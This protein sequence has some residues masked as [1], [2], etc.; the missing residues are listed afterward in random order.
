MPKVINSIFAWFEGLIDPFKDLPVDKPPKELLA[1]YWHYIRQVWLFFVALLSIG[2]V[3]ALIEVSLFA[4]LGEIVDLV[5]EASSPETFFTEHGHMLLWM[6]FVALI[7]RPVVFTI[8]DLLIHQTMTPTFVNMI[9]WQTHRY[10]LRQSMVFFQNDFAGRITTKVIQTGGSLR[11]SA[12]QT[13]DAIWF[14]IIYIASA[15]AL[16]TAADPRLAWPL[17]IW[18]TLFIATLIYFVPRIKDRSRIMSE[19]RSML[20]GRVVD[21]YTNILT[22]KLFAHAERE[23]D[24]ARFAINDHTLKFQDQLRL[25]TVLKI[26]LYVINGALIVGTGAMALWLWSGGAIT[27]GAFALAAGLVLRINN[28]SGWIMWT[29]TAI[30]EHIGIVQDGIETLSQPNDVVDVERAPALQVSKG[31]IR[32]ENI[33][34]NYGQD[35]GVIE[36]LS[37]V[38]HPGEKVGLV[39]P[40]GAGKST[41]VN[42]LL[43]FYDLEGGRIMIDDQDIARVDQESLRAHIGMVTQDTSL[44]HRSVMANVVYGRPEVSE[45][46]AIDAVER[47]QAAQFIPDLVDLRGRRGF[48]AHVGERGVKLS[49]GQRQRVAIARVLLKDA[50]ILILDEATSALDSEVEAAIQEQFDQLMA[51]KTVIAIAHRLSTIAAMDRLVIMDEGRIVEEGSHEELLARDGLYARLWSRQSGGFLLS[52]PAMAPVGFGGGLPENDERTKPLTT[53]P[54]V[55][56]DRS[57]DERP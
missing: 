14:M 3:G 41:L 54:Q 37:L 51:G 6:G 46:E 2:L 7:A 11:E 34:F 35:K 13:T 43:R 4:F 56:A 5:R 49:G 17:L 8:H 53:R 50:P 31:E 36:D 38:I 10:V 15:I 30:F 26:I 21:S 45:A 42:V 18:L 48:D 40:S 52:E 20:T 33:R 47:A 22:V 29:V 1:F 32:Y 23:D 24:Y 44:L 9:R 19:A 57:S 27:V 39:G 12:V 55:L 28:M 25:I 16:F